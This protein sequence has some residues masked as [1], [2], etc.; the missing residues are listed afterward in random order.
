[1]K[2]NNIFKIL[3]INFFIFILGLFFIEIIFGSWFKKSNY[4]SLLIPKKQTNIIESFPYD[5]EEI[6]IYSRDKNGFRA[7]EYEL[8]DIEILI[9]GGSTTEERE[10]DD[11]KI[12]T[13][14]FEKNLNS[15][16]KVLNAGIGGQTSYGHKSMFSLW[17]DKFEKLS[18]KYIILYVG[19]NDALFLLEN[20]NKNEIPDEGR[21][22][23]SSNR[24]TLININLNDRVVQYVKNNSALHTFYLVIKGNLISR[25]FKFNYNQKPKK[26]KPFIVKS[27]EN[28]MLNNKTIK[29]FENYYYNNLININNNANK[30]K[31]KL[32]LVTQ[33]ISNE[34]WLKDYLSIINNFTNNFCKNKKILCID[35]SNENLKIND[36]DFYDGIHTSPK[37]SAII[38]KAIANKFNELILD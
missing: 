1:M 34:H 33:V 23:N 28:L 29:I 25:K 10:V 17:F 8:N 16:L 30:Y 4:G 24:D 31:S 27:P 6:G 3:I 38:G 21:N 37:A 5:A 11:K 15:N 7:N 12:W 26:F 14:V 19:I 32:I 36:N 35:L 22:L 20:L 13:K 18:P 2:L 9:L